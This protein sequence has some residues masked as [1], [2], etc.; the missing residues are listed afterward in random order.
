MTTKEVLKKVQTGELSIE[1]AESFFKDKPFEDL[2]YAH[3]D[4]QRQTRTGFPEVVFCEGKE[5]DHLIEI[6]RTLYDANQAVMGTRASKEQAK[7]VQDV[8]PDA[9]YDPVSRILVRMSEQYRVQHEPKEGCVAV[10]SGG[11]SDYPVAEEAAKTAE[12]FGASVDR[13]Y[14][15]GVSGLHRLL[16]ELPRLRKANVIV[17]VAGMEGTLPGVVAGL[18]ENPV[19]GVPTS[20]GYGTNGKGLSAL[21]T[22]LNSCSNGITVVNIDNGFGAGYVASQINRLCTKGKEPDENART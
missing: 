12:F 4:L 22:M 8:F 19:I 11:T 10:C 9:L 17:S 20:V 5:T 13:I 1:E 6:Y 16:A 18:I 7:A 2:G 15:V 3:L 14:D 21:L